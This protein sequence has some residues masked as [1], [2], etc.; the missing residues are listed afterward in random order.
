VGDL[1]TLEA[2]TTFSFFSDDIENGI[3]QFSSFSIMSFG[4]IVSGSGLSE[5]EVIWSKELSEWSG[6]DGI[7][8]TWF[9]I[10]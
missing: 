10:H 5:N 4:P 7:H 9:K 2:I 1:E 6:S 3:D 8:G